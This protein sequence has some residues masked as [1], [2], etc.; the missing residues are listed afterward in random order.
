MKLRTYRP[1]DCEHLAALFYET[2]HS[3]NAKDYTREQMDCWASGNVNFQ[4]WNASFLA[5]W[6]VVAVEKNKIVGFGDLAPSG[7]LDRLFVHKDYQRK[8]IATA[9]CNH[10]ENFAKNTVM[11]HAS[12]TARPFFEHRG[13]KVIQEQAALRQGISIPYF[14]MELAVQQKEG[15]RYDK[16]NRP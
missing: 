10:L 12:I 7:Y 9:I 16:R 13:Y 3:I 8:G 6:T 15:I 1:S 5:H 4:E 11:T 14:V 2:V